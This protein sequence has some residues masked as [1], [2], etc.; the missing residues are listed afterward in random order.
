[1]PSAMAFANG[2]RDFVETRAPSAGFAISFAE[3]LAKGITKGYAT[4]MGEKNPYHYDVVLKE[5]ITIC[6]SN[7][8]NY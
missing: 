6:I 4:G 7:H 1:M 5:L 2:S 8:I 3:G